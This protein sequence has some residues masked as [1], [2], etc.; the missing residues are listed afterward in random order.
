DMAPGAQLYFATANP[1]AAQFAANIQALAAAGCS[2]IVDDVTYFDEGAFQDGV[3]AQAVN[4]VVG[5]GVTYISSSGDNGSL[6]RGNSGTWEGDFL[7]GGAVTGVLFNLGET[8][9]FHNF[10][11]VGS[12]Q[13]WDV[14]NGTT[15]AFITL[16]WSDALGASG[17]DYDLFILDSAGT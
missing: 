5:N 14:L 9:N 8:G 12:P 4:T 15:T 1:S 3:I 6:T 13:N 17:N 2:I 16:K 10:G 11:T 7:D